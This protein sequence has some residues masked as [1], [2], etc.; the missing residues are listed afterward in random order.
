M[1]PKGSKRMPTVMPMTA[2]VAPV[3]ASRYPEAAIIF[4]NLH[5]MH[6]VVSDILASPRVRRGEKRREL[7]T[8]AARYRD[9]TSFVTSRAD[10]LTMSREMGVERMGGPAIP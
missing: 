2:A 5:A 9:S 7:L 6:D 8:A 1:L 4:D 3:F 10:W